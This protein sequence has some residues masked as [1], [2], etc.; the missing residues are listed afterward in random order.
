MC[1]VGI[2]PG[3]ARCGVAVADPTDTLA[4]P[5]CVLPTE[6]RET[7]AGRLAKALGHRWAKGLVVGLPLN[8]RGGEGEAAHQA[9]RIG[10]LLAEGLGL[11]AVYI[12]ERYS[13]REAAVLRREALG[14]TKRAKR[15]HERIDLYAATAILQ[16][17]LDQRRAPG[18]QD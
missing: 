12:D 14:G 5:L 2:D 17:F 1:W 18:R 11:D 3:L 13:S 16:A 4:T 6:P 15:Q 10:E 8:Q 7:L 9:R